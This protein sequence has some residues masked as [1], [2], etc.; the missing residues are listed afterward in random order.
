VTPDE[1]VVAILDALDAASIPYMIVGSLACCQTRADAPQS[2][3][4]WLAVCRI[5]RLRSLLF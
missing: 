3:Q 1:A 2:G 5:N 4:I